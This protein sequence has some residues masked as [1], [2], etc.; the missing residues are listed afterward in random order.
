MANGRLRDHCG[1]AEIITICLWTSRHIPCIRSPSPDAAIARYRGA[2]GWLGALGL[3]FNSPIFIFAFLPIAVAVFYAISASNLARAFLWLIAASLFFYAWWRPFNVLLIA[4]SIALNYLAA[5][6][7][8]RRR[9]S[10]PQM[11]RLVFWAGIVFNIGFIGYFKYIAFLATVS[12]DVFGTDFLIRSVALPLGVSFIT[13]QKIALLVDARAGRVQQVGLRDYVLF[14]LFF[15]PLISGPIVHFR[16]LMPQFKA[17]DGRWHWENAA[18]GLGLFFSGLFKKLV[19]ADPIAVL[20]NP[21]WSDAAGGGHPALTQAWAAALGYMVQ[22]YFDFSGYSDMATGAARLFGI[23]L[24]TNFNSPLKAASIV[25]YWSRWHITLTRFLTAY[26][27]SPITLA[28]SRRRLERGAS[29]MAGRRTTIPAFLQLL[30]VPT[31]VTMLVSGLWHGAG[32]QFL[33]F[34]ALHG[35]AL[36]INHAWRLWQPKSWNQKLGA[37]FWAWPLTILCVIFFEVFFRASDIGSA[38]RV[39]H[40]MLGANGVALPSMFATKLG[41]ALSALGI[42]VGASDQGGRDFVQTWMLIALAWTIALAMPNTLEIFARLQPTLDFRL[43]AE[44]ERKVRWLQWRP[45]FGW[46]FGMAAVALLGLM[47]LGHVSAFLYWQF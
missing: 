19:L 5:D 18:A 44:R 31:I 26:I 27:F 28:W 25:D 30:F 17:M 8:I 39:I 33:I 47:S 12:N 15:P 3:L 24:P 37:R 34:G 43:T 36:V 38:L 11:T 1:I 4:P 42:G 32:Y 45:S 9:E 41:G 29:G 20:I 14:V 35:A 13:F 23:R 40:G 7:L 10:R 46:S 21:I 6:F 2:P 22:L 16:E